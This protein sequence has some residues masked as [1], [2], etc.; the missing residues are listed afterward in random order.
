M[1]DAADLGA[2]RELT[3][4]LEGTL[5]LTL[6]TL[7]RIDPSAGE[8]VRVAIDP[9]AIALWPAGSETGMRAG[10]IRSPARKPPAQ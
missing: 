9:A 6:R 8:A 7:E 2:A 1:L 10:E 4:A 5:E 3:I